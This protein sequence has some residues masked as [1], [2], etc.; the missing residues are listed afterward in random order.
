MWITATV[1]T[2]PEQADPAP[3]SAWATAGPPRR[4]GRRLERQ[5]GVH[6]V[7]ALLDLTD[8]PTT[9]GPAGIEGG[10]GWHRPPCRGSRAV[11]GDRAV[12]WARGAGHLRLPAHRHRRSSAPATS[13]APPWPRPCSRQRLASRGVAARIVSSAGL[14]LDRRARRC[15]TPSRRHGRGWG[16]TSPAIAPGSSTLPPRW[17]APILLIGM[18]QRHIREAVPPAAR[19]C[20]PAPTPCRTWSA[21][22]VRGRRSLAAPRPCG[23]TGSPAHRGQARSPVEVLRRRPEHDDLEDRR[24]H[25]WTSAAAFRACA[26]ES[27]TACSRSASWPGLADDPTGP[28]SDDPTVPTRYHRRESPCGSPSAPTTPATT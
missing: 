1:S 10:G 17:R 6:V 8:T 26:D 13:A 5:G 9:H 11:N 7:G 28:L 23:R 16:W 20:S 4:A 24:P 18:E 22:D 27:S 12:K 21:A 2:A 15:P 25:R 3:L 19:C 14:L